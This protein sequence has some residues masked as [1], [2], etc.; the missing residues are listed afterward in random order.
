M[1]STSIGMWSGVGSG[2]LF[3]GS[4]ETRHSLPE[5]GSCP[6]YPSAAIVKWLVLKRGLADD[7]RLREPPVP[8]GRVLGD[9][10]TQPP[11]FH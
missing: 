4:L 10:G 1:L 2:S 7:E 9:Q 5:W 6:L 11:Y 8:S 3:P